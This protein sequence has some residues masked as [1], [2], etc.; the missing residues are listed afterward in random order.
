VSMSTKTFWKRRIPFL[1]IA[2]VQ[3]I[4]A[5]TL[6]GRNSPPISRKGGEAF[7]DF[8]AIE[9]PL[10]LQDDKD[11]S[12]EV[13]GGNGEK[14]AETGCAICSLEM[15]LDHFGMHY[16]SKELNSAL[17][18]NGGYTWHGWLRW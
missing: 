7:Q 1:T 17:K 14:L 18:I 5:W 4:A 9:T 11:R 13:I 8:T 10:Y 16:T 12:N 2:V 6:R 3:G 15:A